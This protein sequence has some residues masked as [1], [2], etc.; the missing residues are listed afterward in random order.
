MYTKFYSLPLEKQERIINAA[1]NEFVKNGYDKASTN[2]IVRGAEISKG[3]LFNY[4]N[5]KKDLYLF[6]LEYAT[7]IVDDIYQEIDFN[8][9]DIFK[10]IGQIGRVKLN[11]Q[12][13]FPQVF[14]FWFSVVNEQSAEV[15]AEIQEK[16]DNI[17]KEGFERIYEN[18]DY[19]KFRQGLDIEKAINIL[20]WTMVGFSEKL[21]NE[22]SSIE[23]MSDKYLKEWDSYSEIL[24][25]SYYN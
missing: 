17:L 6:L 3:S 4:F 9:T 21:K 20:N 25:H 13:K 1:I 15:K 12:R 10:R 22:L 16:Q 19:S 14:N 8:E 7:G 24:K 23:E 2:D 11:I 18:I 5:N